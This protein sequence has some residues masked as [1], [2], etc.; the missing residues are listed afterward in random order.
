M[1]QLSNILRMAE[2]T[3]TIV[4]WDLSCKSASTFL[5]AYMDDARNKALTAVKPLYSLFTEQVE[6]HCLNMFY[7]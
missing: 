7:S 6:P 1:E 5:P 4:I 3:Q 2:K